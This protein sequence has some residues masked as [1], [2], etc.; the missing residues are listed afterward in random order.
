M[1]VGSKTV[2]Q[3]SD[4]NW[5]GGHEEGTHYMARYRYRQKLIPATINGK[6]VELEEAHYVPDGQ[7]LVLYDKTRCLGGAIIEK[8]NTELHI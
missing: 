1:P 4:V 2:V 6:T 3:V 5:I 7:S 8:V